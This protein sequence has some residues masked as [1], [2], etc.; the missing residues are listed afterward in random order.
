VADR[1]DE[2]SDALRGIEDAADAAQGIGQWHHVLSNRIVRELERHK[3]L[4]GL[5]KRGDFLVQASDDLSHWGYQAWHRVYDD[6][7]VKWLRE[8]PEA[9]RDQFLMLLREIYERPEMRERFPDAIEVLE[10]VL[11][12]QY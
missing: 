11:R 4:R 6:E 7:V 9:T 1:L 10:K 8:N 3:T 5:F 12:E 2:G